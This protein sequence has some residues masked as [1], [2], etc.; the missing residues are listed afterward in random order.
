[1]PSNNNNNASPS[2]SGRHTGGGAGGSGGR[3]KPSPRPGSLGSTGPLLSNR[4]ALPAMG[5]FGGQG[6]GQG[7]NSGRNSGRA[8]SAAVSGEETMTTLLMFVRLVFCI[9]SLT[10]S[11]HHINPLSKN[12]HYQPALTIH[13]ITLSTA[14]SIGSTGGEIRAARELQSEIDAVRAL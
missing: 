10:L 3:Y 12:T 6:Q 7:L 9:N 1:M 2:V 14:L 8:K 5:G 13:T 11:I 4:G